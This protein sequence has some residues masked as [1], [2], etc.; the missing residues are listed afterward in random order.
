MID[1]VKAGTPDQLMF[2]IISAVILLI[3]TLI[4]TVLPAKNP[5]WDNAEERV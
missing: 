4:F 3:V 1:V 5:D 2:T